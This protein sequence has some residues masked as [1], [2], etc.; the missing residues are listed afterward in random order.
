MAKEENIISC[1]AAQNHLR[2]CFII[3]LNQLLKGAL[4]RIFCSPFIIHAKPSYSHGQMWWM[5]EGRFGL[6]I[7]KEKQMRTVF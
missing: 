7:G 5:G 6:G 1:A 2:Q 3:L 4:W